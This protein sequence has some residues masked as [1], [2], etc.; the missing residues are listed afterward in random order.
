MH[1]CLIETFAKLAYECQLALQEELGAQAAEKQQA[2]GDLQEQVDRLQN[3]VAQ[4][5]NAPS[6]AQVRSRLRTYVYKAI[7]SS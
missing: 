3:Q 4:A 1:V 5:Q 7:S 6:P 2:V